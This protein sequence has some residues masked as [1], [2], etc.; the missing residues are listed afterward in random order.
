MIV[1][2]CNVTQPDQRAL[3]EVQ[4]YNVMKQAEEEEE[5]YR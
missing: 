5:T 4:I 3:L 1:T 2:V